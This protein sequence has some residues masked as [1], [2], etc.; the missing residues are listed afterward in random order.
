MNDRYQMMT[1]CNRSDAIEFMSYRTSN[2]GFTST[3]TSIEVDHVRFELLCDGIVTQV[4]MLGVL[5]V[6]V[7]NKTG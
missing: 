5:T 1:D 6:I 3:I 4:V 7:V 2:E